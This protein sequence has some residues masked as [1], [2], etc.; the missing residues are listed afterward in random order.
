[1][2]QTSVLD[3]DY[4]AAFT[5]TLI[6]MSVQS[7][8]CSRKKPANG[9]TYRFIRR[10]I[11][12]NIY[13]SHS[14]PKVAETRAATSRCRLI[15]FGRSCHKQEQQASG[16]NEVETHRQWADAHRTKSQAIKIHLRSI[17]QSLN[18]ISKLLQQPCGCHSENVCWES[19]DSE[20]H[21]L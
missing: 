10:V 13:V 12:S 9:P 2:E 3:S 19:L 6:E 1:M 21:H 4:A 15:I 5:A 20:Y 11:D 16:D 8:C 14:N 7:N 17:S 18:F